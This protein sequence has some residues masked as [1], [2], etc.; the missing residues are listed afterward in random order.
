MNT[1]WWQGPKIRNFGD[2]LG[3]HILK[4]MGYKVKKTALKD[5][6]IL[7]TGTILDQ[8][9]LKAKDNCII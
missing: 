2:E 5:A 8:A 6:D 1:W 9:N 4:K 3:K 7:T